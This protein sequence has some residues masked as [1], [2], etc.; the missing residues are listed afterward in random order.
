MSAGLRFLEGAMRA[1]AASLRGYA[2]A[3]V[4]V[5]K[6]TNERDLQ[7]AQNA[8]VAE[9]NKL[10]KQKQQN[11]FILGKMQVESQERMHSETQETARYQIVTDHEGRMYKVDKETGS[12][13]E[14][15]KVQAEAAQGVAETQAG[16]QVKTAEIG[17]EAG[18]EQARIGAEAGTEQARISAE[19]GTDQ[20]R[21][22]AE[23][24]KAVAGTQAEAVTDAAK[25]EAQSQERIA[26]IKNRPVLGTHGG[27]GAVSSEAALHFGRTFDRIARS[28]PYKILES[29]QNVVPRM[30]ALFA[31][32]KADAADDL[33]M[34]NLFQRMIDPG[35]SVR[36]GDV[37][38]QQSTQ[39][40]WAR[41]ELAIK[42]V[43]EGA[44]LT[45]EL[46]RDMIQT[47]IDLANEDY[48]VLLPQIQQ[49]G[50]NALHM[51]AELA[52]AGYSV[53]DF[54]LQPLQRFEGDVSLDHG[55]GAVSLAGAAPEA[56]GLGSD[57]RMEQNGGTSG[58]ESAGA[59]DGDPVARVVARAQQ[60][61]AGGTPP[62]AI[63]AGILAAMAK[64]NVPE[65]VQQQTL[66]QVASAIG[67]DP[68]AFAAGTG[69]FAAQPEASP[70]GEGAAEGAAEDE[71]T[72]ALVAKREAELVERAKKFVEEGMRHS[73]V[74]RY[75]RSR[76]MARELNLSTEQQNEIY[77]RIMQ[78]VL[79]GT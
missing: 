55:T 27:R 32:G 68:Q 60:L 1:S 35:V 42:R 14:I 21:I 20:A 66:Q 33:A 25:I 46:R 3:K 26:E 38:L 13:V 65:A 57:G 8:L 58:T 10:L 37:Q 61:F 39:A 70:N 45:P 22:G 11:D 31:D 52:Q 5:A 41:F 30:L 16:A 56:G 40:A 15:A 43:Q 23:A 51:N 2:E 53:S 24:S 64:H 12:A 77:E 59:G 62:A 71:Q 49:A 4:A 36:E 48:D 74:R 75:V 6:A 69:E 9:R 72:Q 17:A 63:R 79:G 34:V 50:D 44:L 7:K 29:S 73:S 54:F 78:Q 19:A 47:A 18:T 28:T 67:V 76:L